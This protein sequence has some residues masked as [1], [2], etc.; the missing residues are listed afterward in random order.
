MGIEK[1][2]ISARQA[3]FLTANLIFATEIE[4]V[5]SFLAKYAGQDAWLSLL[6]TFGLEL[7]FG[8]MLIYLGQRFQGKNPVE[9]S[10][11]LLGPWAGR[12]FG[13]LLGLFL[14]ILPVLSCA[15]WG[16]TG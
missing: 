13:V 8:A 11:D 12:V 14:C 10:I 3:S 1:G 7:L 16:I 5:P 2:K 15:S 4:F 6:I 9:Y